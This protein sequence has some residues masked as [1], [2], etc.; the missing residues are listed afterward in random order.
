LLAFD[1]ALVHKSWI[2]G[3]GWPRREERDPRLTLYEA[4]I[5]PSR[6]RRRTLSLAE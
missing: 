4:A 1:G 3:I 5:N 6:A 2:V